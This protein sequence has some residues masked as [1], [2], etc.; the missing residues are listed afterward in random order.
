MRTS[1]QEKEPDRDS[2]S[3]EDTDA[4]ID[5][6]NNGEMV[7]GMQPDIKESDTKADLLVE[8]HSIVI[9]IIEEVVDEHSETKEPIQKSEIKNIT[10]WRDVPKPLTATVCT[11]HTWN[12]GWSKGF[13][14]L[15][16]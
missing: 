11:K 6:M 8:A 7:E 9:N 15:S 14:I 1:I 13:W 12:V 16:N 5:D 10:S 3:V 4:N 2:N